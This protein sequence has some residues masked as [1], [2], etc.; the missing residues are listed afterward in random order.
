MKIKYTINKDRR[1]DYFNRFIS[2]NFP[3]FLKEKSPDVILVA[4]GD[5][6]MHHAIYDNQEFEGIFLGK[7]LGTFN[8]LMNSF[9]DDLLFLEKLVKDEMKINS[10]ET[11][12]ISVYVGDKYVGEA[13]ND[14]IV[15]KEIDGYKKFYINS[16]DKSFNNFMVSGAGICISTPLGSTAYNF[17]NGGLILPLNSNLWSITGI[18]CNRKIMDI[19][20]GQEFTIL[21]SDSN[22]IISGIDK[23]GIKK[24]EV[25]TLKPGRSYNIGFLDI[26]EFAERRV[27]LANRYRLN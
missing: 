22:L 14:L 15:G 2:K 11:D 27:R 6:A 1:V 19:I 21:A 9:V 16:K 18:V 20:E 12:A 4:G 7:A 26:E 17:N 3:K 13:V 5:G 8:F 23:G 10:V 25:I 24:G